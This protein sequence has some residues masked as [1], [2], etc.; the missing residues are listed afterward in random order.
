MPITLLENIT[1]ELTWF[2]SRSID[3]SMDL[4]DPCMSYN[5]LN[6]SHLLG[7]ILRNYCDTVAAGMVKTIPSERLLFNFSLKSWTECIEAFRNCSTT[8]KRL[9]YIQD[10]H[11]FRAVWGIPLI[12]LASFM[13]R[14]ASKCLCVALVGRW[15]DMSRTPIAGFAGYNVSVFSLLWETEIHTL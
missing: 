14:N 4:I 15:G 8:E 12:C 6:T 5:G 2:L 7:S 1:L 11:S 9:T 10:L 13:D 3:V